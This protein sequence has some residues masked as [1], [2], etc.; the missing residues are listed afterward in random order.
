MRD[1]IPGVMQAALAHSQFESIHPFADGNGRVGRALIQV[2][3]KRRGLVDAMVPPVSLVLAT[4]KN[5]YLSA[6]EAT[7]FDG[8]PEQN[9][10]AIQDW[11]SFF[12]DATDK[13]CYEMEG[14]AR[15]L[16]GLRKV[17]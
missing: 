6:L 4:N 13:A 8:A 3:L 2:I 10:G 9:R 7:H 14:I 1:D 16:A 17:W 5:E 12:A 15:A 11:I